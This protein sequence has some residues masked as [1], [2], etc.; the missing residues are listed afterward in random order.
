MHYSGKHISVSNLS[1]HRDIIQSIG[2]VRSLLGLTPLHLS[3]LPLE[4]WRLLL[5]F[6]MAEHSFCH[7]VIPYFPDKGGVVLCLGRSL[8]FTSNDTYK[9]GSHDEIL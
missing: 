6:G 3:I 4:A 5:R 8:R 7:Y 9:A 1:S 2:H